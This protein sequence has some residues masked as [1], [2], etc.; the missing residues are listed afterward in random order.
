MLFCYRKFIVSIFMKITWLLLLV[1][2]E[3]GVQNTQ[4]DFICIQLIVKLDCP[5]IFQHFKSNVQSLTDI[6]H[7][8]NSNLSFN[9]EH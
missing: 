8:L 1:D 2:S 4:N 9:I 5:K 6:Q 7:H 3:H